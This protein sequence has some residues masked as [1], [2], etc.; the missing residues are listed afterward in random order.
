[1][2]SD[3]TVNVDK[4]PRFNSYL[5]EDNR[6]SRFTG[7]SRVYG[8]IEINSPEQVKRTMSRGKQELFKLP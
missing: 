5:V 6:G 2:K 4:Y 3:F 8:S 1:M 7:K